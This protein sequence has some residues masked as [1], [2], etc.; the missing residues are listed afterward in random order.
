MRFTSLIVALAAWPAL[1]LAQEANPAA[2]AAPPE[3]SAPAASTQPTPEQL[4]QFRQQAQAFYDSL[5]RQTGIISI[6]GGKATLNVPDTHYFLG[7]AD[8][9]RVLIDTWENPP[10]AAAG[11]DGMV[12]LA[13]ANP[14]VDAWGAIVMYSADG[15]VADDEA[16]T[17]DYADLLSSMQRD[18]ENPNTWRRQNNYP[19]VRLAGWAEPPHYDSGA[20]KLYWAKALAFGG[21]AEAETLNYDIR[22]L[23]REGY[24]EISFIAGMQQLT[25][26]RESAPAIMAMAD[27][28][29]GNRYADFDASTDR[30]AAYGIGGLIAGG[31]L[32]AVAQKTG[33]LALTLAFG[34]KFIV[35]LI[36]GGLVLVNWLRGALFGRKPA[37]P[38]GD[39]QPPA[40]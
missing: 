3:A 5:N 25:D 21:A 15:H 8:A 16:A 2:P 29:D 4:E 11:I 13:G 12:F 33:L 20:R 38:E 1:A 27:F 31:A 6:A 22:V 23:G 19:D 18:T 34:K 7:P 24:L 40:G 37:P 14:M 32:A 10:D 17:I 30:V 26:I 28:T 35:L 36:G 9:R 39:E